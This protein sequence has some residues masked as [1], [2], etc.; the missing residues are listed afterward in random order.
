MIRQ[1]KTSLKTSILGCVLAALIVSA[2]SPAVAGLTN[3]AD[4]FEDSAVT[5]AQWQVV[6]CPIIDD[7]ASIAGNQSLRLGVGQCFNG[8][9]PDLI[10]NNLD[11]SFSVKVTF[12]VDLQDLALAPASSFAIFDLTEVQQPESPA[13]AVRLEQIGSQLSV[14]LETSED[15]GSFVSSPPYSLGNLL[16]EDS[17]LR[18]RLLWKRGIRPGEQ[19]SASLDVDG[20]SAGL[21]IDLADLDNGD[22]EPDYIR[23]GFVESEFV[24]GAAGSFV[25]DDVDFRA[26]LLD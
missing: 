21:S 10:C 5:W 1:P 13:V 25:I 24:S 6:G 19:G 4:D 16:Q 2:G 15:A 20:V 7:Q 8:R 26:N 14:R 11:Q 17:L 18:F 9:E 12:W 3:I 23:I 22:L